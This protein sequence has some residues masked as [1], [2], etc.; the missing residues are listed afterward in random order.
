M[1]IQ[2]DSLTTDG[3]IA[4]KVINEKLHGIRNNYLESG[5]KLFKK[6]IREINDGHL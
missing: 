5:Y 1:I 6:G 3:I 4:N 2:V